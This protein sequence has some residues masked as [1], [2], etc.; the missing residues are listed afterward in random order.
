MH[1]DVYYYQET[2]DLMSFKPA[3]PNCKI[4]CEGEKSISAENIIVHCMIKKHL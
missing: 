1:F 4:E 3:N 2:E